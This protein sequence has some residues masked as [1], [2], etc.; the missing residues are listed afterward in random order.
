MLLYVLHLNYSK[1]CVKQPLSKRPKN[2]FQDRLWL[3]AG[4]K[5]KGS[6]L[7]YFRP[8][9]SYHLSLRSLFDLFLSGRFTQ[10]LL[11][12]KMRE[13]YLRSVGGT[14]SLSSLSFRGKGLP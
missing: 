2:G 13:E 14:I 4:Q 6:I 10:V 12:A 9:L 1:T 8:S 3:N 7:Q 5:S 11:Y